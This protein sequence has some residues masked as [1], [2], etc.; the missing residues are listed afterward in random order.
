MKKGLLLV[1]CMVTIMASMLFTGCSQE[2]EVVI[3]TNGDDEAVVAMEN[4]LNAKGYEGKYVFQ[5]Y[6]T[7]ELGGK[8][9]AE[10]KNIEADIVTLSTYYI[11]TAQKDLGVFTDFDYNLEL[12]PAYK[13][14]YYVPILANA[15]SMFANT[16]VLASAGLDAPRSIK[17]LADPKYAGYVSVPD[18]NHS[19][20]GW[21]LIQTIIEAYG[22]EEG[23][24][25]LKGI[26]A[27]CGAHLE[28]SGSG[29]IKKIRAGEVAVGFGLRHQAVADIE[30]GLPVL[31]IDPTEGNFSLTESLAIINKE[32]K[33]SLTDEIAKIMLV[34]AREEM[35][36]S[37]PA[38]L[39]TNESIAP[40]NLASNP[41]SFSQ[42]LSVDLYQQHKEMMTEAKGQ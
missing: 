33:N 25:I 29:P 27:N 2:K 1:V 23:Q 32:S 42:A 4:A 9:L 13:S 11:E 36:A 28:K 37:Y 17:D 19:S 39:Y 40:S 26:V 41:V 31:V 15:S 8:L 21:L 24:E 38:Q 20:T 30:K 14:D 18:I 5:R 7:S 16:E 35:A 34:D 6:G 12:L 10:G 22:E 3:Y